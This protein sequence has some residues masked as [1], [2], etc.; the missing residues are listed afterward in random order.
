MTAGQPLRIEPISEAAV[1]PFG[2]MLGKPLPSATDA[3]AFASPASDFWH[4]HVF[5]AGDGGEPEILWVTYRSDDPAVTRLEVHHL[6]QQAV[7]PVIGSIVQIVAASDAAGEP[8]LSTVRAFT[9]TP[10]QGL[11]MRPGIWHAT[12][13]VGGESTC[14]MLTRGST[15]IDLVRHLNQGAAVEESRM[16]DIPQ[17]HLER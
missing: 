3:T 6:T 2:W 8:D 15:T 14:L 17:L 11:C 4:E 13:S 12:R 5:N 1:T 9:I 16:T 10:G 7:V